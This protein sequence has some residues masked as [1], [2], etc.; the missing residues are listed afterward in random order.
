MAVDATNGDWGEIRLISCATQ[1]CVPGDPRQLF[2]VIPLNELNLG[3]SPIYKA[4]LIG[5]FL[6]KT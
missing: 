6:S 4:G 5:C 2:D 3:P 1:D